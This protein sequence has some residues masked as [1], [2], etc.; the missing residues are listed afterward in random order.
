[1]TVI[2][3]NNYHA[4]K[5]L[6]ENR[7]TCISGEDAARQDIRPLR[8]GFLNIMPKCEDYEFNLLHPLGM[9]I[10]QVNPVWIKLKSHNYKSSNQRHIEELYVSYEDALKTGP[11]DGLIVTGAPVER[12]AF[13]EVEYWD[14][15]KVIL[16]DAKQSCISTLGICWGGFALARLEG[17]DKF[18]YEK[19]L[20]G[21]F[22]ARNLF[23]FHP[24]VGELDDVFWCPQSRHAGIDDQLLEKAQKAGLLNLLAYGPESGYVIFET[25]DHRYIMHTGHPEYNARRLVQEALRDANATDVPKP[26]NFD[27]NNPINRWKGNRNVFFSQWLKYC[28]DQIS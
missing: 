26:A 6:E 1:M 23:P 10:I 5:V 28:Y 2:T 18:N 16:L 11:L 24:I 3:P 13:E 17:I 22:E 9:S 21:V 25:P 15:I 8:I 19:K 12:V 14:E 7:I 4:K 20:F 27:L